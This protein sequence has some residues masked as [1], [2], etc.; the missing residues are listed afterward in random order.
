VISA[1]RVQLER[2]GTLAC[3]TQ[4]K[5]R[6]AETRLRQATGLIEETGVKWE[7][8]LERNGFAVQNGFLAASAR[9][10]DEWGRHLDAVASTEKI[11]RES[12]LQTIQQR[13][14]I[15]H[16][17]LEAL[18]VRLRDDL[19]SSAMSLGITVIPGEEEFQSLV[20]GTPIFDPGS[21]NASTVRPRFSAL[22]GRRFAEK[23]LA[24]RLHE[25]LGTALNKTLG[26]YSEV[27]REWT[28][29]VINQL[30]RRF[31]I[32]AEGYR[33][34]AER[35]AGGRDLAPEYAYGLREEIR[36]LEAPIGAEVQKQFESEETSL[37]PGKTMQH[38]R[39]GE[40]N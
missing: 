27:L 32:Y 15:L 30:S 14:K 16:D 18:A 25:E 9:L 26:T 6:A 34:Q 5:I 12:I 21:L 7:R 1:L 37:F 39:K 38:A 35:I 3:G 24:R 19:K 22:F 40:S 23:W 8:E 31:E 20:R 36:L 33:A 13:V 4:D 17:S 29:L 2:S 28:R 10:I 11:I